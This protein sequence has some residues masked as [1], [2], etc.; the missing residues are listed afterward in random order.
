MI[1]DWGLLPN[2]LLHSIFKYLAPQPTKS[3]KVATLYPWF[4]ECPPN[5]I[6]EVAL[7]C[8][9]WS[10]V[11]LNYLW[12][13]V[14]ISS[15]GQIPT[16]IATLDRTVKYR[17]F[18]KSLD[19]QLLNVTEDQQLFESA[20]QLIQ[21]FHNLTTLRIPKMDKS[22]FTHLMPSLTTCLSLLDATGTQ[23]VQSRHIDYLMVEKNP[24]MRVIGSTALSKIRPVFTPTSEGIA[25]YSMPP[26]PTIE[27]QKFIR[28]MKKVNWLAD[29]TTH[30]LDQDPSRLF[31]IFNYFEELEEINTQGHLVSVKNRCDTFDLAAN[32][33]EIYLEDILKTKLSVIDLLQCQVY[34]SGY[35]LLLIAKQCPLIQTLRITLSSLSDSILFEI[36]NSPFCTTLKRFQIGSILPQLAANQRGG[37]QNSVL[38]Q[39]EIEF[40]QSMFNISITE[41]EDEMILTD[42]GFTTFL[43]SFTNLVEFQL[44]TRHTHLNSLTGSAIQFRN[45]VTNKLQKL[46]LNGTRLITDSLLEYLT[47][48]FSTTFRNSELREL[49]LYGNNSVTDENLLPRLIKNVGCKL[50]NLSLI[51]VD[52]LSAYSA[53]NNPAKGKKMHIVCGRKSSVDSG[54]AATTNG[55][56]VR[57]ESSEMEQHQVLSAPK[58]VLQIIIDQSEENT[59]RAIARTCPLL[60]VLR[61]DA[62]G[63]RISASDISTLFNSCQRIQ[64]LSFFKIED[65]DHFQETESD[66]HRTYSLITRKSLILHIAFNW[67]HIEAILK[68]VAAGNG[69]DLKYLKI[70]VDPEVSVDDAKSSLHQ[71]LNK[72]KIVL[73]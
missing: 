70:A 49:E 11:A 60:K 1:K 8:K 22:Q 29:I 33:P 53:W 52:Q 54:I 32:L 41:Y 13:D 24:D 61:F 62:D 16:I 4:F 14:Y 67:S 59:V 45:T 31:T 25:V 21:L 6:L 65:L 26:E 63:T 55:V 58:N 69:K 73:F 38:N 15:S 35:S 40:P 56:D 72:T 23:C 12:I 47:S 44:H 18:T 37:F 42:F 20:V 27:V 28:K 5:T 7:T 3:Y 66:A 46:V 39:P 71:T 64:S 36:L 19:M 9:V 43:G 68:S 48:A 34:F 10:E 57:K 17:G 51:K 30:G 2:E 50:R